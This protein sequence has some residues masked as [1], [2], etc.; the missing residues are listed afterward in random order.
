[1]PLTSPFSLFQLSSFHSSPHL[2][3]PAPP[4]PFS[5]LCF[6]HHLV[7]LSSD[8]STSQCFSFPSLLF[9]IL[10]ST[11]FLAHPLPLFCH[12]FPLLTSYLPSNYSIRLFF[13]SSHPQYPTINYKSM[14]PLSFS[15]LF[16]AYSS[17]FPP[18]H[19]AI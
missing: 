19:S 3:L 15:L 14:T 18:L 6:S 1:M 8:H 17:L 10:P 2:T 13:H 12:S 16:T 4:L 5:S 11:A 7:S 9:T